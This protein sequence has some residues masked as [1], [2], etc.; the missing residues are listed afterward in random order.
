MLGA[1]EPVVPIQHLRHHGWC[2]ACNEKGA[3]KAPD[4]GLGLCAF[5]SYPG[6]S[7]CPARKDCF[8]ERW[9]AL[10]IAFG[11]EAGAMDARRSWR[12]IIAEPR[13]LFNRRPAQPRT[14]G[15]AAA[16]RANSR[17]PLGRR[18]SIG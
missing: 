17:T 3:V 16:R 18:V 11:W 1:Y 2:I 8:W 10:A 13:I 9:L 5:S 12:C 6:I 15:P 4:L 14:G 7:V